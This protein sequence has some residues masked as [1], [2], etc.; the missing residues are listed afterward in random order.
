[1]QKWNNVVPCQLLVIGRL[2]LD[3]LHRDAFRSVESHWFLGPAS[4][5]EVKKDVDAIQEVKVDVTVKEVKDDEKKVD[6]KL[7]IT[8]THSRWRPFGSGLFARVGKSGIDADKG[9]R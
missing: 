1:M 9:S 8:P 4:A 2:T 3:F 7:E 6:T 5:N